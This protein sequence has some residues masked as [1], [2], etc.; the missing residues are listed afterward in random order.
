MAVEPIGTLYPTNIPGLA[1]AADIQAALRAYHYG[2]YTYNT[3]NSSPGSLEAD[4]MAKFL[5]DIE[6]D[7]T[8]LQNLPSSG[9]EVNATEP[10]VGD[11]SPEEIPDGFV[12][13]DA[14]GSLGGVPTGATA[15]FTNSA[16]VS[17]LTTGTVWVDKDATSITANPFI[18]QAVINAKGDLLAGTANDTVAVLSV[19]TN[20]Y[21]LAASSA[22]ASGLVWTNS[23]A[24]EQTLTNKTLTSPII[25]TIV[26]SGTLTLPTSTDTL[27]GKAT[28]DTFTNKTIS[29]GTLTGSLTAG[30][31][32]GTSGYVLSSTG[33]GVQW[34]AAA[35]DATPTVFML[36]GA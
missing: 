11:F 9:G 1:D 33:S 12:W 32:T 30:A 14:D 17:S 10:T 34:A 27:V 15:V 21:V 36:M 6:T 25:A 29:S 26:N 5:Y 35:T 13:V 2:S 24:S 22:T 18:P 7:I 23:A 31:S 19:G 20:G 28:T 8:A 3:A 16:P 4:S